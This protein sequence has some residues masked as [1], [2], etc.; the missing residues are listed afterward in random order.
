MAKAKN[1]PECEE[2]YSSSTVARIFH[3]FAHVT[4]SV[5]QFWIKNILFIPQYLHT[6]YYPF[7]FTRVSRQAHQA[8]RL[9]KSIA[10][11]L[12]TSIK[13]LWFNVICHKKFI[14][15]LSFVS[16]I[17]ICYFYFMISKIML[18]KSYTWC[19]TPKGGGDRL[20]TPSLPPGGKK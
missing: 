2:F 4:L 16:L 13:G 10:N 17:F 19:V 1:F 9:K 6:Q 12:L 18:N 3:V 15:N 11:Y 5:S 14:N 20:P 7:N 8:E